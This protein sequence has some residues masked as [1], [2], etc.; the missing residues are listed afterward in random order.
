LGLKPPLLCILNLD[1]NKRKRD[2]VKIYVKIFINIQVK[3]IG[4]IL[5]IFAV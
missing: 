3:M 5:C 2:Y 1:K 4:K